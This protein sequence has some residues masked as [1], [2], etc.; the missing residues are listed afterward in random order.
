MS[1]KSQMVE[2]LLGVAHSTGQRLSVSRAR[3]LIAQYLN[4]PDP[5]AYCLTY[6]DPVGE[7]ATALAMRSKC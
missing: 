2:E 1:T 5:V 7:R 3:R 6:S 4:E